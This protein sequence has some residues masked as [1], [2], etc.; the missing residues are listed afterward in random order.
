[1]NFK[2]EKLL[3]YYFLNKDIG[4]LFNNKYMNVFKFILNY[5]GK[6]IMC[7]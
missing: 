6:V 3:F 5:L 2:K 7:I 1:M 4:L